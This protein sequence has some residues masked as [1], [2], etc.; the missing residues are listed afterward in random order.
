MASRFSAFGVA[1]AFLLVFATIAAAL[2]ID[3]AYAAGTWYVGDGVKKDMWVQYQ[4]Q[5]IDTANDQPFIM[6]LWFKD[7]DSKG[8]WNVPATVQYQGQTMNGTLR[9]AQNMAPL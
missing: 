3:K 2:T 6:T 4:I 1:V 7:Q 8:N 9:L 5:Q